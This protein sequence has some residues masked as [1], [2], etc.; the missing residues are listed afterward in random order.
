MSPWESWG[1]AIL[2]AFGIGSI[3][4]LIGAVLLFIALALAFAAGVVL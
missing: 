3:P 1:W 4:F 2:L